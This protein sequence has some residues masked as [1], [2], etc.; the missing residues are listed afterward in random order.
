LPPDLTKQSTGRSQNQAGL[1]R[2]PRIYPD[3]P[4]QYLFKINKLRRRATIDSRSGSPDAQT[5]VSCDGA[6]PRDGATTFGE[7]GE[8]LWE[9]LRWAVARSLDA[10]LI[11]PVAKRVCVKVQDFRCAVWTVNHS[12]GMLKGGE[13]M[14]SVDLVQR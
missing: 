10:E 6:G 1:E 9:E 12:T 8:L 4:N 5:A 11:H 3:R 7:H 13:D 2:S 14:V